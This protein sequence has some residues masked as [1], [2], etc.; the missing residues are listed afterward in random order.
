MISPMA[1]ARV[2]FVG[3]DN[4][5]RSQLAEALLRHYGEGR[6]EV[7]SVGL[8]VGNVD[9]DAIEILIETGIRPDHP[10][11][12]TVRELPRVAFDYVISVC[13]RDPEEVDVAGDPQRMRWRFDDLSETTVD[14]RARL[15]RVRDE[16]LSR[17]RYFIL[18]DRHDA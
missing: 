9:T 8:Q 11:A 17:V 3:R 2:L 1:P 5:R 12:K 4:S 16:I 7:Y 15:R 10:T 13:E 18:T 6:Y 14:R